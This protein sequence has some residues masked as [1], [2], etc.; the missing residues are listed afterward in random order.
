MLSVL[1]DLC[2]RSQTAKV[3]PDAAETFVVF[4]VFFDLL[5]LA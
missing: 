2:G 5:I 4:A 1:S 3:S